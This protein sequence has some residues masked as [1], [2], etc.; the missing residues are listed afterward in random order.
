MKT[1]LVTGVSTGIGAVT[2]KLLLDR[3]YR[4]FGTVRKAPDAEPLC[5]QSPERFETIVADLGGADGRAAV[6]RQLTERLEDRPLDVLVN[7]AGIARL[8]AWEFISADNVRDHFEVNVFAVVELCQGAIPLMR[9]GAKIINVSSVNG[10][11]VT[12]FIGTYSATKH[13]LEAM[14]AS[15]AMELRPRGIGVHVVAPGPV[16]TAIW[17]KMHNVDEKTAASFPEAMAFFEKVA[18]QASTRGMPAETIAAKIVDIAEGKAR[19][20]R[21]VLTV[22]ALTNHVLPKILPRST[23]HDTMSRMFGLKRAD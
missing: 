3:G 7:N 6:I 20:Y 15:M 21:Y 2:A 4:V 8:A 12:P 9:P 5:A 19:R 14:S 18:K 10:E 11:V 22:M 16:R 13:A 23:V 1:A 17:E